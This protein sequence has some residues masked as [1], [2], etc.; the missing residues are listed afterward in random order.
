[1]LLDTHIFLWWLFD[2]S[3]LP[4]GIREKISISDSLGVRMSIVSLSTGINLRVGP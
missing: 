3:R 1:M 4:I 2:D